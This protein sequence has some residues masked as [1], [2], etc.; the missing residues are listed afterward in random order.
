MAK[1]LIISYLITTLEILRNL[2][3]LAILL[4]S[5]SSFFVGLMYAF[6]FLIPTFFTWGKR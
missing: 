4:R 1:F 2:L 6:F 3:L 5:L